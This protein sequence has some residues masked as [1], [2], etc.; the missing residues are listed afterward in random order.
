[1]IIRKIEL[2]STLDPAAF[3]LPPEIEALQKKT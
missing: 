2:D 1:M 3:A